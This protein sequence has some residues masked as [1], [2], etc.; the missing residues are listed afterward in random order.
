MFLL[1]LKRIAEAIGLIWFVV[2]A[3]YGGLA[4]LRG[5]PASAANNPNIQAAPTASNASVPMVM[6]YQGVAYDTA[7]NPLNGTY[8]VTFRI[9]GN[10]VDSITNALW[11][12]VHPG[13]MVRA[14]LFN[15]SLGDITPIPPTLFTSPD[16]FV[17]IAVSPYGELLPRQR[18]ASVPYAFRADVPAGTIVAFAGS[19]VPDGWLLCNGSEVSRTQ[20]QGLFNAISTTWGAGNGSTTFKLPDL[21][22]RGPVGAGQ[23][24][25]LTNRVLAQIGGEEQHVLT[26]PEM[27]SHNHDAGEFKYLLRVTGQNTSPGSDTTPPWEPDLTYTAPIANSGGGQ[28]HNNMQPFAVVNF[29]IKY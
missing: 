13:V 5:D 24:S 23:S 3:I 6:N 21:R 18:F 25:G 22:G 27:P 4:I 20:Y 12:E 11:S 28:S 29:I 9:Y 1:K 19:N 8:T 16:R 10:V 14:G 26:V 2:L 7:G 15:V 17:G